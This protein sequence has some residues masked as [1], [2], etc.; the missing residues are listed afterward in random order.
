MS[1]EKIEK[2]EW[3]FFYVVKEFT[4]FVLFVF[5][6][7]TISGYIINN[8]AIY[9]TGSLIEYLK[10]DT[11]RLFTD[12]YYMSTSL[13]YS[14]PMNEYFSYIIN[15][16]HV[17]L[18]LWIIPYCMA[19]IYSY[20]SYWLAHKIVDRS[21]VGSTKRLGFFYFFFIFAI[22]NILSRLF[23]YDVLPT[24]IIGGSLWWYIFYKIIKIGVLKLKKQGE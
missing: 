19:I 24:P 5:I 15:E 10:H 6:F 17:E 22:S 3:V 4:K 14:R 13:G 8:L 1:A 9:Y 7:L 12:S 20:P 11:L 18:H 23:V 16:L 21:R 2:K